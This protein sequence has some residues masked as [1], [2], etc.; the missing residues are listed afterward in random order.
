[1]ENTWGRR[2][3]G[4]VK[5]GAKFTRFHLEVRMENNVVATCTI[6]IPNNELELYPKLYPFTLNRMTE[7]LDKRITERHQKWMRE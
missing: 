4:S 2:V 6:M 1:M 5:K 7:D 3:H